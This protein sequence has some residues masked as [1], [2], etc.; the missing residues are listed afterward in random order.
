MGGFGQ[1]MMAQD[2][3]GGG[4]TGERLA[5]T[6]VRGIQSLPVEFRQA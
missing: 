5:S 3:E 1:L 4:H 2:T 6:L